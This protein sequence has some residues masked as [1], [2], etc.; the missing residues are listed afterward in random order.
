MKCAAHVMTT[1]L[2]INSHFDVWRVEM[3]RL[4]LA[5]YWQR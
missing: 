2:S 1:T 3:T 5:G 4:Q